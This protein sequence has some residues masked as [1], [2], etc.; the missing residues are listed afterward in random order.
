M[1]GPVI[2][3][4]DV[5]DA[6]IG[7]VLVQ[8]RSAEEAEIRGTRL[9]SP[10]RLR[11]GRG[12]LH[13]RIRGVSLGP[14][15]LYHLSYAAGVTVTAPPMQGYIDTLMP[16]RGAVRV[17]HAGDRFD[18]VA[19][20]TAAVISPHAP[21]VLQW[22]P[23]LRLAMMRIEAE[24]LSSFARML[25]GH[26]DLEF[27]LDPMVADSNGVAGLHGVAHLIRSTTAQLA[28]ASVW[29]GA[30]RTRVREQAMLTLLMNQPDFRVQLT[31]G[32]RQPVARTAVR[33]AVELVESRPESCFTPAS[34]A[35][36]VGVSVR[37]L[38][39]GFRE[40]I[41]TTPGAFI[42]SVRLRR[43][44]EELVAAQPGDGA[45]VADIAHRWGFLNLG[46]FAAQYHRAHGECPSDTLRR[47]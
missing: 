12:G 31:G 39:M 5:E 27:R 43:V 47:R 35:A 24:A 28:G 41:G 16:V 4:A 1:S 25:T 37:T 26:D 17:D 18:A 46:R 7:R 13:A 45:T 2:P 3:M 14:V 23:G 30:I 11:V 19:G 33:E 42:L 8:T 6:G 38:Q 10:H 9:L 36:S 22:S 40:E 20:R 21:M 29:P 15:A 44:R 32:V 34:L